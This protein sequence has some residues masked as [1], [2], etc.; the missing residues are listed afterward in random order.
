MPEIYLHHSGFTYSTCGLFTK[1]KKSKET[2]HS[3]NI[4]QNELAK[5]M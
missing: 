3:R 5:M 1:N 4:D 2:G